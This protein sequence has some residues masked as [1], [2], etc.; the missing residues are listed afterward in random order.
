METR[1]DLVFEGKISDNC[2]PGDARRNLAK[3][4]RR[5]PNEIDFPNV[6]SVAIALAVPRTV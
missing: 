2:S 4:L 5:E 1:Y 6:P 3:L